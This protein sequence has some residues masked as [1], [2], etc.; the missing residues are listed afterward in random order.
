ML[1]RDYLVL[2]NASHPLKRE[3]TLRLTPVNQRDKAVLLE[4]EAAR[5]LNLLMTELAG[6]PKAAWQQICAV[7]GW[8]SQQE[9]QAIWEG[10]LAANGQEFTAKYVALPGCSEHQTGLAID[11]GLRLPQIDFIRPEFPYT[12]IAGRFRRLAAQFGFVE[13]YP[14]GKEAVCGIAHEPWHFRYVGPEHARKMQRLGLVL[15]EYQKQL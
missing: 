6:S 7:S 5:Q 8:R 11:L 9:Q 2:V 4:V 12:G 14:Q 10:S 1:S 3:Y 15:E 13:R